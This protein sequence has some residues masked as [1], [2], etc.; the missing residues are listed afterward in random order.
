MKLK[1]LLLPGVV[2]TLLLTTSIGTSAQSSAVR[3]STT[4]V[5][6]QSIPTTG[7]STINADEK[8]TSGLGSQESSN[9][10]PVINVSARRNDVRSID[11]WTKSFISWKNKTADYAKYL[12]TKEQAYVEQGL[13][14]S[15]YK[16]R[17]SKEKIQERANT[18]KQ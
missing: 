11:A 8:I 2:I 15:L 10:I 16:Y 9:D 13:W 1:T 5:Q 12:D 4:A 7:G 6:Q 18:A 14:N 17:A 3:S